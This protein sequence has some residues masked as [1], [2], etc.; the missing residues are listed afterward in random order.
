MSGRYISAKLKAGIIKRANFRCEYCQCWMK[1]AI[2]TFNIDH[3]IPLDNKGTTALDNLAL[4]CGGCNSAKSNKVTAT[5]PITKRIVPIFNPREQI[6]IEHFA[7][8]N[9]FLEVL[10]LT[11]I[12]GVSRFPTK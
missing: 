9:T 1:N 11:P 12:L 6:W 7:W 5:D 8:S 4:S 2:H 10:G 3:V